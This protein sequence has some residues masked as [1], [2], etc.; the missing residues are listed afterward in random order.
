MALRRSTVM[1]Y[2]QSIKNLNQLKNFVRAWTDCHIF[3][4]F[5]SE[6]EYRVEIYNSDFTHVEQ[7]NI[8]QHMY[9]GFPYGYICNKNTGEEIFHYRDKNIDIEYD[10]FAEEFRL[11]FCYDPIDKKA[12]QR[13]FLLLAEMFKNK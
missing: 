13:Q 6:T 8:D 1:D 11:V 5:Y 12:L 4:F 2:Q 3:F 9:S 7:E 10:L